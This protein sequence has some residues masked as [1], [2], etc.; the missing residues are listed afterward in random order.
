MTLSFNVCNDTKLRY[1]KDGRTFLQNRRY[2]KI[3]TVSY[4]GLSALLRVF[5][6]KLCAIDRNYP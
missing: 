2:A 4:L 3:V 1:E 6:T 5:G